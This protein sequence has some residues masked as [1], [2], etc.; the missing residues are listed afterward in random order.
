VTATITPAFGEHL[1]TTCND[2]SANPVHLLFNQFW[3]DVPAEV[4]AAYVTELAG[5]DRFGPWVEEGRYAEPLTLE[6]VDASPAGSLGQAYRT[7]L[8]E[9]DLEE[10]LATN[11]RAF[12]EALRSGGLLDGMPEP[13]QFAILRGFQVHDFFHVITGYGSDPL[14]EIAVQAL[15]LAQMRFPYFA[16]WISV[17]TTRAAFIDPSGTVRLMDAIAAGWQYGRAIDNLHFERWEEQIDEP[18]ADV[19]RR[20]GIAPEGG[21]PRRDDVAPTD[22]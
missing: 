21:G 12:H 14:G 10:K 6:R 9:N 22:A 20:Y 1:L 15:C 13:L 4:A 5:D 8:V 18:L 11:Y 3:K 16:M 17:V 2:L 19:R 7:F